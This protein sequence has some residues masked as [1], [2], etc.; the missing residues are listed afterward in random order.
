M[1]A[2][3]N[4]GGSQGKATRAAQVTRKMEATVGSSCKHAISAVTSLPHI[5]DSW[6]HEQPPMK[7]CVSWEEVLVGSWGGYPKPTHVFR[8]SCV[9]LKAIK[10]YQM[11][12]ER[13]EGYL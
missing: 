4:S 9:T 2:T 10:A 1:K 3:Q 7:G 8:E 12:R 13:G 11:I 5:K 6:A